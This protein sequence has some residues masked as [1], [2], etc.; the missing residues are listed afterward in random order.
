ML[1]CCSEGPGQSKCSLHRCPFKCRNIPSRPTQTKASN[2]TGFSN[3]KQ[4]QTCRNPLSVISMTQIHFLATI[5]LF[6]LLRTTLSVARRYN[7][8][9]MSVKPRKFRSG[10]TLKMSV[11]TRNKYQ[12]GRQG[13]RVLPLRKSGAL[14][15]PDTGCRS[16]G[17]FFPRFWSHISCAQTKTQKRVQAERGG[18]STAR[19]SRGGVEGVCKQRG[20]RKRVQAEAESEVCVSRG[21]LGSMCKQGPG[22]MKG[23]GCAPTCADSMTET[24][25]LLQAYFALQIYILQ[26]CGRL[27]R[28]TATPL[29]FRAAKGRQ[30]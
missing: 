18:G 29:K 9:K 23:R 26:N 2:G 28:I 4:Q 1:T 11:K 17:G 16:S 13:M 21:G 15:R 12:H 14:L 30:V 25:N 6:R 20:S 8:S 22:R 7:N 24:N 27:L 10:L 19:A 5:F 3:K